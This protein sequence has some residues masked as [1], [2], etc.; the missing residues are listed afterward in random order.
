MIEIVLPKQ[1]ASALRH[2]SQY[3]NPRNTV[4]L[5]QLGQLI[6]FLKRLRKGNKVDFC[7]RSKISHDANRRQCCLKAPPDS[8]D[9]LMCRGRRSEQAE[10]KSLTSPTRRDR[11]AFFG[12]STLPEV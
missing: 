6:K 9:A 8:C 1:L 11:K 4:A 2:E 12:S 5:A 7:F 10:N 3:A